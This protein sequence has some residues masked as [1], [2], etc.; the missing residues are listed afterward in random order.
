MDKLLPTITYPSLRFLL[1]NKLQRVIQSR[2]ENFYKVKDFASEQPC[3]SLETIG[4]SIQPV[5][6]KKA[7]SLSC[8]FYISAIAFRLEQTWQMPALEIAHQVATDLSGT[9]TANQNKV[10]SSWMDTL[11]HEFTAKVI[12]PGWLHLQLSDRGLAIWLQLL[13]HL[14][15]DQINLFEGGDRSFSNR[16]S[17]SLRLLTHQADTEQTVGMSFEDNNQFSCKSSTLFPA[18]HAHAR[19]CSLLRLAHEEDL[20]VLSHPDFPAN[21]PSWQIL[22]PT[23]IPWLNSDQQIHLTHLAERQLIA[24]LIT[25]L[26]ELWEPPS[27]S[28][29]YLKLSN[30]LSQAFYN[31]HAACQIFGEVRVNNLPLAQARLA[32]VLITQFLLRS[33]LHLLRADAPF[34]L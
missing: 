29:S 32:L 5:P 33:L 24:Q 9:I 20:L 6:L 19:C 26:D 15:A 10:N 28:K 13:S 16:D 34:E 3:S 17:D 11:W 2:T 4:T 27:N 21:E 25:V 1:L 30:A 23:F 31:F 12:P 7:K 22:H 14:D 8:V 18:K